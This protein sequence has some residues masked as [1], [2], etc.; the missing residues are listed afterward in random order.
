MIKFCLFS[1]IALLIIQIIAANRASLLGEE[2]AILESSVRSSQ[3][4]NYELKK[5]IL[6]K[7]TISTLDEKAKSQGYGALRI[8]FGQ[9]PKTVASVYGGQ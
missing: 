3:L 1:T 9:S 4:R 7:L 8:S 2:I 6:T 5:D